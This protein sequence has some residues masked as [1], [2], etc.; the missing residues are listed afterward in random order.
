MTPNQ[1]YTILSLILASLLASACGKQ[2]LQELSEVA[3]LQKAL[4]KKYSGE[5]VQLKLNDSTV[6]N[7]VFI[8]SPLNEKTSEE[9]ERRAQETAD[10]VKANYG[11]INTLDEL[12]VVFIRQETRYVIVHYRQPLESFSFDKNAEP[13]AN[14]YLGS[15]QLDQEFRALAVYSA[16]LKQTDVS[17]TRL[18][19]EG[20]IDDGL[21]MVP[22]FTVAGDAR[23]IKSLPPLFVSLDFAHYGPKPIFRGPVKI[24]FVGDDKTIFKTEGAFSTSKSP[25]GVF[26]EFLHLEMP[27]PEF[28]QVAAATNLTLRMGNREIRLKAEQLA[29]LREMTRY[30]R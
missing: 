14:P 1:R 11:S 24:G 12:W 16:N 29:G 9:R 26:S 4:G 2:V 20:T 15:N 28:Q 17:I 7:I 19:L 21:A 27:Y 23:R 8:N 6:L 3:R 13:M 30:V 5:T 22:H 10:F 25:E 18:Q